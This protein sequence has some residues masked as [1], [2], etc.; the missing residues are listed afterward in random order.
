MLFSYLGTHLHN[1]LMYLLHPDIQIDMLGEYLPT[2]Y[3][4]DSYK[5]DTNLRGENLQKGCD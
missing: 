1:N 2:S 4:Q 3:L 5:D